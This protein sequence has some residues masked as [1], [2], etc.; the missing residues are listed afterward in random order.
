MLSV[1]Q[2]TVPSI[3]GLEHLALNEAPAKRKKRIDW[4]SVLLALA[5]IGPNL[6]LLLIFTYRPLIDN[7][8]ISFY[9]WNISS[10]RMRFIGLDNYVAYFQ[11]PESWQI[12]WQTF[13]FTGAA[14][15]GSMVLGLVLALLLDR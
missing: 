12:M 2:V 5:L 8:R 11:N 6:A 9:H 7:I 4:R 13:I 15:V 14:V 3:P 10:P 1:A